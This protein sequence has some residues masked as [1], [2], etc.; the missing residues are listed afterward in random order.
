M[1]I[2]IIPV[3]NIFRCLIGTVIGT[4]VIAGMRAIGVVKPEK[5]IY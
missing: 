1:L 3:E 4:G 5:A 2:P